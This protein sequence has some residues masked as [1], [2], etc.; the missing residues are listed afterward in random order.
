[1]KVVWWC[2]AIQPCKVGAVLVQWWV[3]FACW[4]NHDGDGESASLSVVSV[5]AMRAS[6]DRAKVVWWWLYEE[7]GFCGGCARY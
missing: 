6:S 1:M 5:G 7:V 2:C 4:S 3:L